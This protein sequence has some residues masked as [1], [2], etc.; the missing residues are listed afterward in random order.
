MTGSRCGLPT[1]RPPLA[2]ADGV[3]DC[4]FCRIVR[5]EVPAEVVR[6]DDAVLVFRDINPQAPIHLLAI[7]RR[8]VTS[9][10]EL[11]L[12]DGDLLAA[13]FDALRA[14]AADEGAES[15]RLVT[16]V[17]PDAGQSVAHL[18]V[19]LLAGRRLA[20]PPG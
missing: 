9:A 20:W 13:L 1:R 7:P 6:E 4:L 12:A 15:Y 14:A 16:N 11:T 18:H 3:E 5:G 2:Y 10:R 19:H 17:G 8:H